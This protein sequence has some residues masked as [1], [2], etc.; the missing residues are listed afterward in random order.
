MNEYYAELIAQQNNALSLST[1]SNLE[2][3]T[4]IKGAD[5]KDFRPEQLQKLVNLENVDLSNCNELGDLYYL[6]GL[7]NLRVLKL[8]HCN[9]NNK[10][11]DVILDDLTGSKAHLE[12]LELTNNMLEYVTDPMN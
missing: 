1:I 7:K 8:N 12:R 10:Q 2:Q 3:I 11:L 4:E 6:R 9:L 5:Y